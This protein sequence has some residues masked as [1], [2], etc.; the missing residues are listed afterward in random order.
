MPELLKVALQVMAWC[1]LGVVIIGMA[2]W[3]NDV[4]WGNILLW[5]GMLVGYTG[6]TVTLWLAYLRAEERGDL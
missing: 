3:V 4:Q 2:F 5:L 6:M 1:V